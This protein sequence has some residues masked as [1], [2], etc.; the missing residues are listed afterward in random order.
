M[1]AFFVCVKFVIA[2][3]DRLSH[4]GKYGAGFGYLSHRSESE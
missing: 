2:G 3:L 1:T 4:R